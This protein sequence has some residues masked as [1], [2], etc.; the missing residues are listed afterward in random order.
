MPPAVRTLAFPLAVL[1]VILTPV[2]VIGVVTGAERWARWLLRVGGALG[3]AGLVVTA[4]A[5]ANLLVPRTCAR[6]PVEEVNRPLVSLVLGRG[7]CFRSALAQAQVAAI[8][9]VA[10][11]VLAVT[12]S[13]RA[14][15]G[16]APAVPS[17]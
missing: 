7:D 2:A 11:S 17:P 13:G 1:I 10:A 14:G 16:A 6:E 9:G 5:T 4:V 8:V 12:R 3:V 15:G